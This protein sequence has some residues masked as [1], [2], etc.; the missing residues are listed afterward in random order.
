MHRSACRATPKQNPEALE[1]M[2]PPS[3]SVS[4]LIRSTTSGGDRESTSQHDSSGEAMAEQG[5]IAG[6]VEARWKANKKRWR[7]S[8]TTNQID[9]QSVT[10]L[11]GV[12]EVI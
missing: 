7:R 6:D 4:K 3:A 12:L 2:N 5:A 8:H 10:P 9:R 1:Q 11:G